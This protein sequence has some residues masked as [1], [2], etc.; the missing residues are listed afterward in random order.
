MMFPSWPDRCLVHR[1]P[2]AAITQRALA[3]LDAWL[4]RLAEGA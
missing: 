4:A 1:Q 2:R 3:D